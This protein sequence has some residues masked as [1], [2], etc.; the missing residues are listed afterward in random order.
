MLVKNDT[1]TD[2]ILAIGSVRHW[3]SYYKWLHL[4]KWSWVALGQ[5][6]ARLA[7]KMFPRRRWLSHD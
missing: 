6:T 4:G 2:A 7:L 3:N 1:V 5:Q